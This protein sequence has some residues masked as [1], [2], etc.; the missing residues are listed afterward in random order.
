MRTTFS[1]LVTYFKELATNHKE[2]RHSETEKHFYRFEVDEVLTGINKLKYPAFILEGYRFTYKDMKADNPVK[3]RQG[4]FILLDHVGDPGNHDKIHEVW[5]RLEEIG[6]DILSRINADKR[7]K[8]SPVRD[9]DLESVEGSLLAT[10]LG[11][12]YGIRFTFD[13]DCRYSRE[14]DPEKWLV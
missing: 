12:H 8:T 11:N 3:K 2:I 14:V 5:D 9:F 13:I 1:E 4:A 7:D 6:D 10:E